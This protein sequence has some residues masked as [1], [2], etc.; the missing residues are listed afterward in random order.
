MVLTFWE[1][2]ERCSIAPRMEERE[3]NMKIWKTVT[4]LAKEYDFEYDQEV[5]VS[6]DGQLA[7]EVFEAGLKAAVELGVYSRDTQRNVRFTEEEIQ[8]FLRKATGKQSGY[9]EGV[10]AVEVVHRTPG[11]NV[12]PVVYGAPQTAV[13]STSEV[14]YKIY[15]LCAQE[16]STD[17]IWGGL[18]I[19]PPPP[20]EGKYE[21]NAN[22]PSEIYQYRK[23]VEL[24][25]KAITAV[26]RPGMFIKQNAPTA[27]AT[28]ALADPEFGVRPTDPMGGNL[29]EELKIDWNFAN[30]TAFAIAYHTRVRWSAGHAFIGGFSG[31]PATA[32]IVIVA[33][34]LLGLFFSGADD[35][36]IKEYGVSTRVGKTHNRIK[37]RAARSC[38][39]VGSLACQ[40]LVRNTRLPVCAQGCDHPV[41]GAGT[42]QFYYECAAGEIASV[43]S[44]SSANPSGGARQFVCPTD[45]VSPLESKWMG[46]ILK[47]SAGMSLKRAKGIVE[48]LL[49]RYEDK[50]EDGY[51]EGYTFQQMY[52]V[53]KEAVKPEFERFYKHMKDE[54]ENLG[55]HFKKRY[56]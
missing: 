55:V 36:H 42:A 19:G 52:D 18:V 37:S 48:V 23:E 9:G 11:S 51:P 14:A 39:Y 13:Y 4:A 2:V 1:A 53:E 40:A 5:V 24:M 22:H 26:S 16:P 41:A 45:H 3:F 30:R 44:G 15:K 33:G 32:P 28:I 17:G 12:E 31:G 49:S 10:D 25:R 21:I 20:I 43:A 6:T 29:F 46:E 38:I 54:L 35:E 8:E 7:D 27:Q 50:L 34:A 56:A 47:A